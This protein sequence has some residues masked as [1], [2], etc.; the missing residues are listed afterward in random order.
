MLVNTPACRLAV[1]CRSSMRSEPSSCRARMSLP[2]PMAAI[3][4]ALRKLP[5]NWLL[6]LLLSALA[7]CNLRLVVFSL[8]RARISMTITAKTPQRAKRG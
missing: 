7:S 5:V 1:L 2:M 8:A 6:T 4:S 3:T